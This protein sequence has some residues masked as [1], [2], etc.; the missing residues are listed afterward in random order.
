MFIINV[1]NF[2]GARWLLIWGNRHTFE[3][4]LYVHTHYSRGISITALKR[5]AW[6]MSR[7]KP[8]VEFYMQL[9]SDHGYTHFNSGSPLFMFVPSSELF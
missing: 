8:G 4:H 9:W 5:Q 1:Y 7:T 3:A 6:Y 2:S